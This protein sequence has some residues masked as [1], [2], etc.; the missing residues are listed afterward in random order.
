VKN[1]FDGASFSPQ[2]DGPRLTGQLA[3][4][5]GLMLNQQWWTLPALRERVGGSEAGISAR[6]RDLR[7]PKFGGYEIRRRRV[8]AGGLWEYRLVLEQ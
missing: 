7:K 2:L 1:L 4:V 5:R 3:K 8:E 6:I